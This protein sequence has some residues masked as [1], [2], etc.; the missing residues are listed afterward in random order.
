MQITTVKMIRVLTEIG[1]PLNMIKELVQNRSPE[2]MLKLLSKHK[3]IVADELLFLEALS[4]GVS[5]HLYH[6]CV[7]SYLIMLSSKVIIHKSS[8][9][10]VAINILSNG[11]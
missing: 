8:T 9:A 11:S 6:I 3:D 1:V 4:N 5:S 7:M 10:A 2:K